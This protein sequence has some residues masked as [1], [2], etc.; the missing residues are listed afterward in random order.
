M[1]RV[2]R[3]PADGGERVRSGSRCGVGLFMG[4]SGNVGKKGRM[5]ER[6]KKSKTER[7]TKRKKEKRGKDSLSLSLSYAHTHKC[8]DSWEER[9]RSHNEISI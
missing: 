2:K 7:K 9:E 1:S 5:A 3:K 4:G 6:E 8:H